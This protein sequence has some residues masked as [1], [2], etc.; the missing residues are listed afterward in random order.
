MEGVE[1]KQLSA[2]HGELIVFNW[3]EQN[4]GQAIMLTD[5]RLSAC[6]RITLNGLREFRRF[7]GVEIVEERAEAPEKPRFPRK[8]KS[9][10]VAVLEEALA[11]AA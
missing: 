10:A 9:D 8:K 2:L 1:P 11:P 4:T 6:Y 3:I 5:G 7:H